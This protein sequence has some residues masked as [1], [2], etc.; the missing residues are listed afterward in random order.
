MD[1]T[2]PSLS[3]ICWDCDKD[4]TSLI[5]NILPL[6]SN[7]SNAPSETLKET[8]SRAVLTVLKEKYRSFEF[9]IVFDEDGIFRLKHD[10]Y[11]F[12]P[13]LSSG[14]KVVIL[15]SLLAVIR[16]EA[17]SNLIFILY[18]PFSRLD[19]MKRINIAEFLRDQIC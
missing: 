12:V 19:P 9:T 15:F 11:D 8:I 2:E 5:E 17:S 13:I 16:K 1:R 3:V 10:N 7:I 18:R 14:D 4:P 6:L